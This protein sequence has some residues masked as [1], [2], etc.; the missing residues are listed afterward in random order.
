M[1]G[2]SPWTSL[3]T[4]CSETPPFADRSATRTLAST[5]WLVLASDAYGAAM[6]G[7]HSHELAAHTALELPPLLLATVLVDALVDAAVARAS[8]HRSNLSASLGAL[9]AAFARLRSPESGS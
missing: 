1:Q 5:G 8:G 6:G 2:A 3:R 9:L 4:S 7:W